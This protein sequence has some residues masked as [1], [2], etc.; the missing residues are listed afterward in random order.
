MTPPDEPGFWQQIANWLWLAILPLLRWIW[1]RAEKD[2]QETRDD[3]HKLRGT[4]VSRTEWDRRNESVD[5][6][7]ED[8]RKGEGEIHGRIDNLKD[9][10][11]EGFRETQRLILERL[12]K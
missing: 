1:T 11:N 7:L 6:L 9:A 2:M 10:M 3:L 4:A 5:K 12:G 8:R